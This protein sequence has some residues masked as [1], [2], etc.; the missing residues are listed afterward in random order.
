MKLRRKGLKNFLSGV[1][2]RNLE[3]LQFALKIFLKRGRKFPLAIHSKPV[4]LSQDRCYNR[5]LN[6]YLQKFTILFTILILQAD[7]D[8]SSFAS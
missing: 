8:Y 2:K 1:Q 4:S 3:H 6:H 5:I 7:D